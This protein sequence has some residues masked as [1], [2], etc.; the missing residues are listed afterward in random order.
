MADSLVKLEGVSKHYPGVRALTDVSLQIFPGKVLALA[1]ENGAGKSTLIKSLA[2]AVRPDE[3][4]IGV[5]GK[6][7]PADPGEVIK[8]GVSVI[9]Q[10]LTDVPDMSIVDNLLLGA[11]P[12]S[13]GITRRNEAERLSKASLKRVGL[14][15][16]N[17][18][19]SVSSLTLSERQ[20]LEIARCLAREAK[21][22]VFDEPTSSL[23]ESEVDTLMSVIKGLK[24]DGLGILYVSHHLDEFFEIADDILV[25]R[26]GRVVEQRP[27]SD[28]DEQ[29]L[30]RAMLARDLGRAYPYIERKVG[31]DV[32]RVEGLSAP[33]V[34]NVEVHVRS[35]EV[36]GLIGL[37][38]A[39]RTELMRAVAGIN[40]PEEG[41]VSVD[42]KPVKT[43]SIAAARG[44]GIAY[45][46][47]DRKKG[48][49]VL[50]G[51]VRDNMAFGN[52]GLFSQFGWMRKTKLARLCKKW[53]V[54]FGV[55]TSGMNGAVGSLSGGN[56]QKVV[57]ARYAATEPRV[58][59]LDDPTRGVD[60]GSKAAIYE[61]VFEIA[62]GGAGVM[63]TSSDTD[64][65]LAVCDRAYVIRAGRI[66]G[67]TN[68]SSFD[69]EAALH[70]ASLG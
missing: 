15:H 20:L 43:G 5:G 2:G 14:G 33:R 32:L 60:V 66:V 40:R 6:S 12:S 11:L 63:I 9:Y 21:V 46:T 1:G 4:T 61:K 65:V 28:W 55:R 30:V 64:E 41:H 70:L 13:M 47:E 29:Q 35:G 68:R 17:P 53:I 50:E 54:D 31:D 38:G 62:E 22:L 52:Y 48:G 18:W 42:G 45:V 3:G 36:V 58:I 67:E 51:S 37:A 23:A 16:L 69:R 57:L 25:L 24:D 56:Q 10:E 59:L 44:A 34:N 26:D 8:A 27:T 39:G 49:L 19:R 7:V